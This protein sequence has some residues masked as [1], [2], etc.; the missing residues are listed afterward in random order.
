MDNSILASRHIYELMT[1]SSELTA[2]VGTDKIYPLR[3]ELRYDSI[4]GEAEEIT[5]P[6]I[7]YG[8][9]ALQPAYTKDFLTENNLRY[10]V[11]VVAE[12]YDSSLEVANAARH[13]LE[14]K[15][16]SGPDMSISPIRLESV[17]EETLEDTFIQTL[18]FSMKAR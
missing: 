9:D 8:R 16:Y 1:L 12:D 6:F 15:V 13:A 10:K 14:G 7:I 4:S 17:E 11:I 3:V 2:L 18:V 5:F